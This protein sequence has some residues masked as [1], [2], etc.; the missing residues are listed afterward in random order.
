MEKLSP[1]F[2]RFGIPQN[3]LNNLKSLNMKSIQFNSLDVTFDGREATIKGSF[4]PSNFSNNEI[5]L[6]AG[7]IL[8]FFTK[9]GDID[10]NPIIDNIT[11]VGNVVSGIQSI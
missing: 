8:Q 9:R 1:I 11:V 3:L 5:K 4:N 2:L 10:G 6:I 7:S